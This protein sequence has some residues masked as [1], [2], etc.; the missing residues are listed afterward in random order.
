MDKKKNNKNLGLI[1]MGV[2]L[3]LIIGSLIYAFVGTDMF[4]GKET[5]NEEKE[6]K[7]KDDKPGNNS[8]SSYNGIYEYD[9]LVLKVYG[10]ERISTDTFSKGGYISFNINDNYSGIIEMSDNKGVSK[11]FEDIINF[12]F[13]KDSVNVTF[14]DSALES[15]Q[16]FKNGTFKKTGKYTSKEYYDDNIGDS[17][18]INSKYNGIYNY[19]GI[20]LYSFQTDLETVY[21]NVV[22]NSNST[23]SF[24]GNV[25]KIDLQND[26]KVFDLSN[27]N[28]FAIFNENTIDFSSGTYSDI[29]GTYEKE[30]NITIDEIIAIY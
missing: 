17:N 2:G 22:G 5:Q 25:Y 16:G 12:E 27:E 21:I 24:Y 9:N 8:I 18:L 6:N 23:V 29:S 14:N 20:K 15:N 4:K 19:N 13:N 11:L 7:E 1:I 26:N 3:L 10:L 28:E 30:K